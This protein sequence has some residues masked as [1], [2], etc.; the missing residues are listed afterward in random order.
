MLMPHFDLISSLNNM[1]GFAFWKIA[2]CVVN[3]ST[4]IPLHKILYK[5][6]YNTLL[7]VIA[8]KSE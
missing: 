6:Q 1:V 7:N 2:F 3:L 8:E 4:C 5:G